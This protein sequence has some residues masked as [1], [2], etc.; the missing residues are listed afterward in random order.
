MVGPLANNVLKF[1]LLPQEPELEKVDPPGATLSHVIWILVS[2]S[3]C[4]LQPMQ[5][6]YLAPH[7]H[8]IRYRAISDARASNAKERSKTF[9]GARS[10]TDFQGIQLRSP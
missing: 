7:K 6:R 8:L 2:D 3:C 10:T 5:R 4:A 9:L 1:C